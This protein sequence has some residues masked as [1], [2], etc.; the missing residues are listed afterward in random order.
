MIILNCF[1]STSSFFLNCELKIFFDV[2]N[3]SSNPAIKSL[4]KELGRLSQC[5]SLN[6]QGT[7]IPGGEVS[8]SAVGKKRSRSNLVQN[9]MYIMCSKPLTESILPG[10]FY[11][12]DLMIKEAGLSLT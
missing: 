6:I 4:P 3:M 1:L 2:D 12:S 10:N 11:I 8:P 5:N 9:R 7:G